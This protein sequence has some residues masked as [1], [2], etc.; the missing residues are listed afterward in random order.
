MN[1]LLATAV[2]VVAIANIDLVVAPNEA[3]ACAPLGMPEATVKMIDS[4]TA[5]ATVAEYDCQDMLAK[6]DCIVAFKLPRIDGRPEELVVS[7]MRFVDLSTGKSLEGFELQA[8]ETTTEAFGRVMDGDWFGFSAV[9]NAPTTG[10][11]GGLGLE[12]TFTVPEGMSAEA[13]GEMINRGHVAVAEG[14]TQGDIS[15]DG[16]HLEI[17][18]IRSVDTV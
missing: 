7:A 12:M 6:T 1:R 17:I 11:R 15:P 14:D 4:R 8:N 16:H 9:F 2:A 10:V 3:K 5:T 13:L 18:E